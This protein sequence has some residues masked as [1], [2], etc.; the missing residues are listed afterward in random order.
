[1]I[2]IVNP[3][4]D[5]QRGDKKNSGCYEVRH[6]KLSK[7]ESRRPAFDLERSPNLYDSN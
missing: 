3:K 4:N 5:D 7:V 1:M 2:L 6:G